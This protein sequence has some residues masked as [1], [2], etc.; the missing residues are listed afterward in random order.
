MLDT[1][2]LSLNQTEFEITDMQKFSPSAQ[3]LYAPPFYALGARGN[4]SCYQNPTK[5]ELASGNYKPRLTLT[6][7][8][9]H[10]GYA[11]TL[12]CEFSAPKL[13][14]GNNFSELL[15][16]DF[17]RLLD[18]LQSSLAGMGVRIKK[19]TL[20]QA[21]ISAIHYSKNIPLVDYTSCAM[22][23]SELGKINLTQRLDLSKT[24]YRNSGHAIR[25]HAN[26]YELA[27]YDKIKDMQ[28]AQKNGSKRAI[29][30]DYEVQRDLFAKA[31]NQQPL[32]VLR[33]ELRI[34]NRT[35]LKSLMQAVGITSTMRF[36]SLFSQAISKKM[37][38]HFWQKISQDM[39]M[40]ALSGFKP[41]DIYHALLSETKGKAKPAKLL[42]QIGALAIIQNVGMRGLHSL[43]SSHSNDRTW[44]R[45]KKELEKTDISCRMKYAAAQN[46]QRCLET[47]KPLKIEE[48][49]DKKMAGVDM[50]LFRGT[51]ATNPALQLN[52]SVKLGGCQ[53]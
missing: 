23:L 52:N 40:L 12:R 44:Q 43:I 34:G 38:Q 6:K 4:F 53:C 13:L 31:S 25:Y 42:Q 47:F 51:D 41:E 22:I 28:Q 21:E 26:S 10:A 1:I 3:G 49:M 50:T 46:V 8:K 20:K 7:R 36:E 17:T 48:Y 18:K 16:S 35:K 5:T 45:M 19:D 39:P 15:D 2:V 32:E 30:D 24:D 14:L 11:V 37:L 27:F 33:M 29:E 9:A